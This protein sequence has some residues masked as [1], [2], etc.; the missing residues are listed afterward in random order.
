MHLSRGGSCASAWRLMADLAPR[1]RVVG[2]VQVPRPPLTD[3]IIALALASAAAIELAGASSRSQ[4]PAAVL[5]GSLTTLP[6]AW[7]RHD[8]F[9]VTLLVSAGVALSPLI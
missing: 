4:L 9:L 8:P 5:V 3:I 6:L 1:S 7:R 2:I